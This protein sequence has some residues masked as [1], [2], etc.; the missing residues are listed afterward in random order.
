MYDVTSVKQ[1]K[2]KF[3]KMIIFLLNFI[4]VKCV[5]TAKILI[6]HL[7]EDQTNWNGLDVTLSE[8]IKN[9]Q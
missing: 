6:L 5:L 1:F 2:E 8:E 7:A 3:K 4:F 9:S